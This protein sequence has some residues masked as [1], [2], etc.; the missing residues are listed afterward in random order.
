MPIDL[1]QEIKS[2]IQSESQGACWWALIATNINETKT[3][4]YIDNTSDVV[5]QGHT[6]EAFPFDLDPV[7]QPAKGQQISFGLKLPNVD[8]LIQSEIESDASFGSGWKIELFPVWEN[9]LAIAPQIIHEYETLSVSCDEMFANFSI[10]KPNLLE[11][12]YPNTK[13]S[14]MCQHKFNDGLGCKYSERGLSGI[15]DLDSIYG[16]ESSDIIYYIKVEDGIEVA[17]SVHNGRTVFSGDNQG[18]LI[19]TEYND[20]NSYHGFKFLNINEKIIQI[21][22]GTG[23]N[24][25]NGN[26]YANP[27][28]FEIYGSN[29]INNLEGTLLTR[30]TNPT[31]LTVSATGNYSHRFRNTATYS[32]YLLKFTENTLAPSHTWFKSMSVYREDNLKPFEVCDRTLNSCKSRFDEKR[33]SPI[34]TNIHGSLI[35]DSTD[36][37]ISLKAPPITAFNLGYGYNTGEQL[38]II[39]SDSNDTTEKTTVLWKKDYIDEEGD[40]VSQIKVSMSL[41]DEDHTSPSKEITLKVGGAKQGL[42]I[43]AFLG[44]PRGGINA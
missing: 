43:S 39:G 16:F 17:E 42:P 14:M 20:N 6:Y 23:I 29:D 8:R 21:N 27:T 19:Q 2:E 31:D 25:W 3:F 18:I 32:H 7:P 15:E 40:F 36:N 41:T 38:E 44:I 24:P 13:Y 11:V 9:H 22:I 5:Y 12:A 26:E 4:R 30:V 35:F 33:L 37:T 10:G 1:D 34:V 28:A